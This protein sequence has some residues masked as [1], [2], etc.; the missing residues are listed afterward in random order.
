MPLDVGAQVVATDPHG[1]LLAIGGT[2]APLQVWRITTEPTVGAELIQPFP[3]NSSSGHT[4]AVSES[5]W[6]AVAHDDMVAVWELVAAR[7][8]CLFQPLGA[9]GRLAFSPDGRRLAVATA[10]QI[11]VYVVA[12]PL[13]PDLSARTLRLGPA[14]RQ[15]LFDVGPLIATPRSAKRLVNTYRLLRAGLVPDAFDRLN[16]GEVGPVILLLAMLVGHPAP[17]AALLDRLVSDGSEVSL[18]SII[19]DNQ[20]TLLSGV[21]QIQAASNVTDDLTPYRFW[22][23]E[24]A[25]F[26]FRTGHLTSAWSVSEAT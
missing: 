18:T 9:P 4:I 16:A 22:S 12:Q 8:A 26:S 6:V 2:S 1:S 13:G 17:T 21:E 7:L 24:V 25:R 5:G 10:E 11:G 14:E 20:A 23:P 3:D 15:A 19:P